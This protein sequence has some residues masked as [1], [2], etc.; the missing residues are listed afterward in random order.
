M[1]ELSNLQS[2]AEEAE[3]LHKGIEI[4]ERATGHK[5]TGW[6]APWY[7]FSDNTAD[8]LAE[9]GFAYDSSLMGDDVPYQLHTKF[10]DLVELPIEWATDDWPQYVQSADLNYMM[11]IRSPDRAMEVFMAE[12][13]AAWEHGG[14]WIATWHP[15]V[16]GRLSRS[17]RVVKMIEHMREK[18]DVWLTSLGEIAAHINACV[19]D[20]TYRPR[21]DNLP[22][23]EGPLKELNP[24]GVGN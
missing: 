23:L 14:L 13:D 1:H 17:M 19:A 8:L 18:G 7:A 9:A 2:R 5:P 6:R 15:F 22:Y 16:S 20:G 4:T 3:T 10:G 11:P 21:V 12:F 24:I